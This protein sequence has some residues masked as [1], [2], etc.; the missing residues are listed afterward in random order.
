VT[1]SAEYQTQ[2]SE[3][4]KLTFG[5]HVD[6]FQPPPSEGALLFDT[7]EILAS[8]QWCR[9]WD[10]SMLGGLR[11]RGGVGARCWTR[12]RCWADVMMIRFRS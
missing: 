9:S 4:N 6:R 3:Q 7:V 1:E 5:E 8:V 11:L 2:T 10:K 12:S